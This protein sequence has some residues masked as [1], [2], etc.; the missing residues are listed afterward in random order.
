[1]VGTVLDKRYKLSKSQNGVVHL[2]LHTSTN[3]CKHTKNKTIKD[4]TCVRNRKRSG[5]SSISVNC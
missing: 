3:K 5:N 2:G 4:I 1:M